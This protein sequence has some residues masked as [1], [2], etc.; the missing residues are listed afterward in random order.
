MWPQA[1]IP[2]FRNISL[3]AEVPVIILRIPMNPEGKRPLV[4]PRRG[5]EDNIKIDLQEVECEGIDWIDLAQD[6]GI[7]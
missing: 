1:Y 5:W 3:Q 6:R 2:A 4:R 7:L